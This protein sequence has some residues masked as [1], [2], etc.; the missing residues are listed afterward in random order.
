[1]T[2]SLNKN[3]GYK[4]N[5][6]INGSK[7]R[8]KLDIGRKSI[9]ELRSETDNLKMQIHKASVAMEEVLRDITGLKRSCESRDN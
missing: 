1:M 7:A 2:C 9:V 4:I 6:G 5:T 8:I 3:R